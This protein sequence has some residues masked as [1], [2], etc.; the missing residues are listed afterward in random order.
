MR[1]YF[2]NIVYL[3]VLLGYSL[4]HAGSYE[5][6]FV[7]IKQDNAGAI[8]SLLKRGFDP[9]TPDAQGRAWAVPGPA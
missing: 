7:A 6:F 8:T 3:V 9:N 5:D 2:K 4:L 1:N